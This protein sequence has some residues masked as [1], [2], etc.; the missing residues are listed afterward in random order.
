MTL[1]RI[2]TR[3][4][5]LSSEHRILSALVCNNVQMILLWMSTNVRVCAVSH[6]HAYRA[7]FIVAEVRSDPV[8]EYDPQRIS[9]LLLGRKFS[10]FYYN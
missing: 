6:Q 9:V 1:E 10:P 2:F 7:F 5:L 8:W 3:R 4:R